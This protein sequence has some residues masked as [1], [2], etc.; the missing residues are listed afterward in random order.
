MCDL[1]VRLIKTLQDD[2]G[3]GLRRRQCALLGGEV[4][5]KA[6][7][8]GQ[9]GRARLPAPVATVSDRKERLIRE[10]ELGLGLGNGLG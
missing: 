6:M 8:R 3:G 10:T 9:G 5:H 4:L 7:R 1:V 2:L